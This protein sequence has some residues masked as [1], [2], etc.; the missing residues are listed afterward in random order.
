MDF[1]GSRKYCGF[2]ADWRFVSAE[3]RLCSEA[4]NAHQWRTGN[5]DL[6][7]GAIRRRAIQ[8]SLAPAGCAL[9]KGAGLWSWVGLN[10]AKGKEGNSGATNKAAPHR[11]DRRRM[12]ENWGHSSPRSGASISLFLRLV[13]RLYRR[14]RICFRQIPIFAGCGRASGAFSVRPVWRRA[15]RRL[16]RCPCA[17]TEWEVHH[18]I[19]PGF[20]AENSARLA[21]DA[22]WQIPARS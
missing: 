17:D 4:S 10:R 6:R 21:P 19:R 20:G 12:G 13:K 3:R 11:E 14:P 15:G 1:T 7:R 9:G 18:L 8:I 5:L 2:S 22:A 16:N